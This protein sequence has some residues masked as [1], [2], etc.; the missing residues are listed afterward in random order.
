MF[1]HIDEEE[2][3]HVLM[4]EVTDDCF[5]EAIVKIQDAFVTTYSGT[6]CRSQT[7]QGVRVCIKSHDVN[8]TCMYVK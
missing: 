4:D 8:T 3:R 6:K 7:I 5:D 1:A 2:N